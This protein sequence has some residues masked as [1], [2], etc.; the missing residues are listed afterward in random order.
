[1]VT[2][3]KTTV[4][5]SDALLEAAKKVAAAEGTTLRELI[6]AGLRQTL[7]ERKKPGK[8]RLRK[9]SFRGKGLQGPLKGA[10]WDRL[11]EI[12]YEGRGT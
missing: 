8:F 9:A 12:S 1:M 4:E 7:T 11:R 2:H 6:E 10:T 5:I 3:M